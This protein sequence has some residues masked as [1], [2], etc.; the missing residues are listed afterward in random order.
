MRGCH[1]LAMASPF[2]ELGSRLDDSASYQFDDD[3][4]ARAAA[5][6]SASEVAAGDVLFEI[7]RAHV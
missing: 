1:D 2:P 5:Y 7:G 3:Q 6:G 4:F